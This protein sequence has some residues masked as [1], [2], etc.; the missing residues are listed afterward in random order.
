VS[1]FLL[2]DPVDHI[3]LGGQ[4]SPGIAIVRSAKDKRSFKFH[5]VP[6]ATGERVTFL[7][8]ELSEFEVVIKCFT[9][10]DLI[11]FDIWRQVFAAPDKRSVI[12]DP[13][14][15]GKSTKALDIWHPHLEVL[16]ITAVN[17][18]E[19]SQF[20]PADDTGIWQC[21]IK[22]RQFKGLPQQTMA[23]VAGAIAAPL[24]KEEQLI[25]TLTKQ[26]EQMLEELA[27]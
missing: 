1:A 21:T 20:E 17:V 2:S 25:Q 7:K 11:A 14:S 27:K 8:R 6:F 9:S 15:G 5:G 10:D 22:M 24:S 12:S 19:V 18:L 4:K 16:D 23:T 13:D 3:L 26:N